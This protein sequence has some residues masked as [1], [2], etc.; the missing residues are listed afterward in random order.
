MEG[1]FDVSV[2][3]DIVLLNEA[4][5]L[6][7]GRPSLVCGLA[8]GSSFD[9]SVTSFIAGGE[10]VM[11]GVVVGNCDWGLSFGLFELLENN[12]SP[13]GNVDTGL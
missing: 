2:L 6:V 3:V 1:V 4:P 12:L 8:S 7:V 5:E 13:A 10:I 9:V 11:E